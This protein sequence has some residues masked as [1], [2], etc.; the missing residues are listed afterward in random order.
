MTSQVLIAQHDRFNVEHMAKPDQLCLVVTC[1]AVHVVGLKS[2][3]FPL[4]SGSIARKHPNFSP[5]FRRVAPACY[6]ALVSLFET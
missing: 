3:P 6:V 5:M 1:D 4:A 2:A